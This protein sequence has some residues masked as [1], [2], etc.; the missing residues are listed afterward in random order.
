PA[1]RAD[2]PVQPLPQPGRARPAPAVG[3][4]A[5]G[6]LRRAQR[7]RGNAPHPGRPYRRDDRRGHGHPRAERPG[8]RAG[9]RRR[10]ASRRRPEGGPDSR[11]PQ[12][13]RPGPPRHERGPG[14]RG[15]AAD[16]TCRSSS[17]VVTGPTPPGT[18]LSAPATSA[19]AGSTSPVSPPP[20]VALVPTSTT[21]APVAT[22]PR[23]TSPARP[24]ATTS[25]SAVD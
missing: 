14:H 23:S 7:F 21:T 13:A 22:D 19:T 9:Y 15:L 1:R 18:G 17:A 6:T 10:P 8:H 12:H 11:L 3:P 2:Q 25:T 4:R 20:A 16:T 5:Q 24:A